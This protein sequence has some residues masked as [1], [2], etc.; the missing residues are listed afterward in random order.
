MR[1]EFEAWAIG[2]RLPMDFWDG[3]YV[4][5][6]VQRR[7]E[8]WQASRSAL[9]V[10]KAQGP[11]SQ[12]ISCGERLPADGDAVLVYD[13]LGTHGV[14]YTVQMSSLSIAYLAGEEFSEAWRGVTHWMPLPA[15]PK[16]Q[17]GEA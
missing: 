2:L 8:S 15:A 5:S 14:I 16:S 12:W 6:G 4:H 13:E 9:L 7:W 3:D 1:E 10:V 11:A 17:V